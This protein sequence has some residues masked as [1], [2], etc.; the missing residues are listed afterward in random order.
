M[1]KTIVLTLG[2]V[3]T[4]AGC[5][6]AGADGQRGPAGERGA[7]GPAGEQGPAG[8]KGDP[9]PAGPAGQASNVDGARLKAKYLVG[10]DG[11]RQFLTWHDTMLDSDCAYGGS[12]SVCVPGKPTAGSRIYDDAGCSN[13]IAILNGD[14]PPYT[15]FNAV[16]SQGVPLQVYKIGGVASGLPGTVYGLTPSNACVDVSGLLVNAGDFYLATPVDI[17][18]LVSASVE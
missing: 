8:A 14:P 15:Y 12:P 1:M 9:G 2:L 13:I 4:I 16:P 18:T 11:S 3:A 6:S 5:G 17:A 10:S 7:V